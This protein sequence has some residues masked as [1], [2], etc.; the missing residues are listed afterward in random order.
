MEA[1]TREIWS[2]S[3]FKIRTDK[4]RTNSQKIRMSLML[5]QN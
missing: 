3:L 4:N 1:L 5:S 2:H